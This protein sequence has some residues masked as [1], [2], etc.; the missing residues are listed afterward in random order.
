[1]LYVISRLNNDILNQI[2][3]NITKKYIV[4]DFDDWQ[5]IV[6]VIK[7]VY[8]EIDFERNA[9][10]KLIKLYQINKNFETFWNKF[11][12]YDKQVK[13]FNDRILNYLKNRFFNEIND[14]LINVLDMF[15]K[16]HVFVKKVCQLN[17]NMQ[18]LKKKNTCR[19]YRENAQD[20]QAWCIK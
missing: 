9:R 10:R 3:F 5:V 19:F 11:H 12:R 17:I 20:I 15:T 1:M 7:R 18:K 16:L 13:M 4:I 8:N 14:R 6:V 2:K